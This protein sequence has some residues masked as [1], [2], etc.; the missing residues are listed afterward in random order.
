[1]ALTKLT[2]DMNIIQKLGDEPNDVDGLSAA[3]L[4]AKFDEG[5][6]AMKDWV[7]NTFIPE[8]EKEIK[9]SRL[10]NLPEHAH[11]HAQDGRDP[12][13]PASIGAHPDTWMPTAADVGAVS[14]AGGTM[15]GTLTLSPTGAIGYTQ[16]Y[17]N[18]SENFDYGTILADRD[19]VSK[20]FGLKLDS[21]RSLAMI[22]NG[23]SE[24]GILHTGNKPSG[25]FYGT[26][27]TTERVINTGGIGMWCGV[28]GGAG[29]MAVVGGWGAFYRSGNSVVFTPDITFSGGNLT[30]KTSDILNTA[31][32]QYQYQVY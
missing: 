7:N 16:F 17:K 22:T 11:T 12:I 25:T 29:E 27:S 14:N 9:A 3:E 5:N 26:G 28:G 30:Y 21:A 10:E 20:L 31:G 18:A 2:K 13:T 24:Y 4:K 19:G 23:T 32:Y 6:N 1:M 8:V 15:T